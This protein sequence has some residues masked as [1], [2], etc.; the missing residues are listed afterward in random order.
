MALLLVAAA[1]VGVVGGLVAAC[2]DDDGEAT[3]PTTTVKAADLLPALADLGFS[4]SITGPSLV[5]GGTENAAAA[6]EKTTDPA[7]KV[8][9]E[10]ALFADVNAATSYFDQISE[11]MLNPNTVVFGPVAQQCD[12]LRPVAGDR[13]KSYVTTAPDADG[14]LRW[15]DTYRMGRSVVVVFTLGKNIPDL[16]TIRN[17]I[18]DRIM[19]TSP[20]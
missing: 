5:T 3:P 19:K 15:T 2:G 13:C 6:Y 14:N 10:V 18:A 17:E 7:A 20:V 11:K 12:A 4:K 16:M 1:A 9:V 8:Q